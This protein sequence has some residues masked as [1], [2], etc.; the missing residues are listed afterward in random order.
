[1]AKA[2]K[3]PTVDIEEPNKDIRTVSLSKAIHEY[4]LQEFE[5]SKLKNGEVVWQGE[6][7]LSISEEP[8]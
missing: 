1:M 8:I 4:Q 6:T 5:V 2:T 7:A 3:E